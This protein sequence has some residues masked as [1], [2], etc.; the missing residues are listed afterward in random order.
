MKKFVINLLEKKYGDSEMARRWIVTEMKSRLPQDVPPLSVFFFIPK[1][2]LFLR[3]GIR[4]FR[5]Q[6]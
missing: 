5:I 2:L 4:F 1:I 3:R 6:F